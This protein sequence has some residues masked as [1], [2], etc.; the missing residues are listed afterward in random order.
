MIQEAFMFIIIE[1]KDIEIYQ[2]PHREKRSKVY[3]SL[4]NNKQQFVSY[5][6]LSQFDKVVKYVAYIMQ[7][8]LFFTTVSARRHNKS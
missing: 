8:N 4:K 6:N 7:I 1:T 2:I 5:L 3:H